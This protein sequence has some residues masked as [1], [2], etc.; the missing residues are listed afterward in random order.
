MFIYITSHKTPQTLCGCWQSKGCACLKKKQGF[1]DVTPATIAKVLAKQHFTE[2]Y[3]RITTSVPKSVTRCGVC[4]SGQ[5][6]R[7]HSVWDFLKVYSTHALDVEVTRQSEYPLYIAL[8]IERS[9]LAVHLRS[10]SSEY[11]P[12]RAPCPFPRPSSVQCDFW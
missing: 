10:T 9:S 8:S 6:S 2:W 1:A 4:L 7:Q 11:E 3:F 12:L 5:C